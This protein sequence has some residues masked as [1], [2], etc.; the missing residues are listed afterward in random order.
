MKPKTL[1][2]FQ[3]CISV[4]LRTP[5]KIFVTKSSKEIFNSETAADLPQLMFIVK[6]TTLLFL[7]RY[8]R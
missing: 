7:T 8:F 5:Q 4:P 6:V 3:I 1:A 2:D